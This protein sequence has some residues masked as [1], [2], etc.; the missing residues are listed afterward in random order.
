M[1]VGTPAR[2]AALLDN[3]PLTSYY[4]ST[5]NGKAGSLKSNRIKRI[6]VDASHIDMKKRGIL[7]MQETCTPLLTL[8]NRSEFK[9][10]FDDSTTNGIR[11]LF[12]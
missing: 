7:D 2:L 4:V 10:R 1:G 12:Y 5:T 11:L 8:L 6:V 9:D 3:G